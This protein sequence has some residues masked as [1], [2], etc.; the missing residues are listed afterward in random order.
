VLVIEYV[1]FPEIREPA[2]QAKADRSFKTLV[3]EPAKTTN[4]PV[5]P[6]VQKCTDPVMPVIQ[7][8]TQERIAIN[9]RHT[10]CP[11]LRITYRRNTLMCT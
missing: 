8:R 11:Q 6:R 3:E 7:R 5:I 1:S 10:H 9:G 2:V 4:G